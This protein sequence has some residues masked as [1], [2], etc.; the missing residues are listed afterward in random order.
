MRTN[1]SWKLFLS[2]FFKYLFSKRAGSLIRSVSLI[3][4]VGL[5]ISFASLLVV[6]SVMTGFG[7]S[8]RDRLLKHEPHLV[9]LQKSSNSQS[10]NYSKVSNHTA[11]EIKNMLKNQGLEKG[12]LFLRFFEKQDVILKTAEGNFTGAEARGYSKKDLHFIVQKIEDSYFEDINPSVGWESSLNQKIDNSLKLKPKIPQIYLGSDLAD[13]LSIYEGY[14]VFLLPAESLLLPPTEVSPPPPAQVK[15]LIYSLYSSNDAQKIFYEIGSL[16]SLVKTSS[17]SQGIEI[18]FKNPENYLAYQKFFDQNNFKTESWRERNSSLF[19]ALKI[20]KIIMTLFLFLASLIAS[21]SVVSMIQ[22]LMTQKRREIGIL[23]VMGLSIQKIRKLFL[24]IAFAMSFVGIVCG[25]ILAYLICLFLKYA[26]IELLP[27]IYVDRK[28]PVEMH[29]E[30]FSSVFI[31]ACFMAYIASVIPVRL[32]TLSS[33]VHLI[34][35]S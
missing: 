17:L 32:H 18:F 23:M 24:H 29:W 8:I 5:S 21:F 4:I 27:S 33:P 11:D 35:K 10:E 15:S 34:H 12:L 22:L 30:V 9:L 2:F 16:P 25:V 14:Q 20:E 1:N 26:P 6:I 7:S 3:C 13:R 28:V 19:F 31:I